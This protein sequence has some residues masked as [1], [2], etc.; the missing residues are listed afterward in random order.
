[1]AGRGRC[2]EAGAGLDRVADARRRFRAGSYDELLTR[3]SGAGAELAA[4]EGGADPVEAA[5]RAL[6]AAEERHRRV[7]EE[8]SAARRDAAEPFAEAVAAE[9]QG[10]GMGEG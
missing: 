3:A 4:L 8:L 7:A 5:E 1:H 10:I 9:L 2:E 6:A